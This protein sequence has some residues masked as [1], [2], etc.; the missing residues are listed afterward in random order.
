MLIILIGGLSGKKLSMETLYEYLGAVGINI[1]VAFGA[2]HTAR[3]LVKLIPIAG[4]G[5]SAS[6][7]ATATYGIGKSAEAYFFNGNIK[8]AKEFVNLD[9]EETF[10]EDVLVEIEEKK[11]KASKKNQIFKKIKRKI[12]KNK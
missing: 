9:E 2:K 8:K 6:V 10:E 11:T 7:A 1:G 4:M 3:Q 12:K 5:I